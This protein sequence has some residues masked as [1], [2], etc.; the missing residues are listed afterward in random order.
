MQIRGLLD[1]ANSVRDW[2]VEIRRELHQ[3]PELGYQEFRTSELVRRELEEL[4]IPY[5]HPVAETG[6]VATLG[7]GDGPCVALR[8][9][10]DA[11]P[12]HEEA[13][14]PFRSKIEGRMHACGHDCHTAMLLGA[15]RLLKQHEPELHGTVRLLFQ[16]AE[17]GG[18]GGNRMCLEGALE[19]PPVERIF[20]L[21]VWPFLPVGSIGSRPGTFLATTGALEIRITGK[22]GHGAMPHFAIDPVTTA[23]KV[24]CEL[25]TIVSRE[26]DPLEPAVVSITAIHAGEAF[27][28]IPPEVRMI[29][30]LRS[31]TGTGLE[32][33]KQRVRE[34]ATHV[35]MANRCAADVEFPGCDYPATVNDAECWELAKEIGR[36]LLG[37]SDVH[38]LAPVMGG[39]DFAYYAE[40]VP[41]C[42]IG[43]GVRNESEDAVY[44]VH[45]PKFKVDED[46]LPIGMALH[47]AFALRSLEEL[48]RA[49]DSRQ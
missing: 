22:G 34:I 49:V 26:L 40:R 48:K 42:F 12:V 23:A 17:E 19:D 46:A 4:G 14:V 30:T 35:A 44:S 11:L 13:E 47:V 6:V 1:E 41:G 21:H 27:N 24:V 37:A 2:V 45:H 32:F 5:R 31:L 10:M 39:E 8:A 33:L 43:L 16:P 20:G 38:E 29:G 28:V 18:A 25:Q 3:Y 7:S 9:D 15:A 36:K